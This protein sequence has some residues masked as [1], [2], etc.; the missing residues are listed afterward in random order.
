[1]NE[2]FEQNHDQILEVSNGED[3]Y[4]VCIHF[5]QFFENVSMALAVNK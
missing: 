1:M 2:D 5:L 3:H 4:W